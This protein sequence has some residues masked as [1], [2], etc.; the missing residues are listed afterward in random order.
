MVTLLL[1]FRFFCGENWKNFS[2]ISLLCHSPIFIVMQNNAKYSCN[3][4]TQNML[5]KTDIQLK[6]QS[7]LPPH[8]KKQNHSHR[9]RFRCHHNT[10]IKFFM[11]RV[12]NCVVGYPTFAYPSV[13]PTRKASGIWTSPWLFLSLWTASSSMKT[14]C[15]ADHPNSEFLQRIDQ[16]YA[17]N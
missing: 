15:V 10:P 12:K 2:K 8:T 3:I 1:H 17:H 13:Y 16:P 7:S 14:I 6:C 4:I 11:L 5:T 9:E